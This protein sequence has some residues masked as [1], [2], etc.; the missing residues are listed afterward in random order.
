MGAA[1]RSA[2]G[3]PSSFLRI[4]TG[5]G[6]LVTRALPGEE[7]QGGSPTWR[8]R[9]GE[10]GDRW[11]AGPHWESGGSALPWV[12]A[13]GKLGEPHPQPQGPQ[14]MNMEGP[15]PLCPEQGATSPNPLCVWPQT[16]STGARGSRAGARR[17]RREEHSAG[18]AAVGATDTSS[19]RE[20]R[21]G[22]TRCGRRWE[23][24][25]SAE[26]KRKEPQLETG[27]QGPEEG[28]S[29]AAG[30]RAGHIPP[31][32]GGCGGPSPEMP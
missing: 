16:G 21:R 20:K 26:G 9:A 2:H 22:P 18:S 3:M 32:T 28:F 23:L 24:P 1:V 12:V 5:H 6:E 4:Y 8:T 25:L 27:C 31:D 17:L 29:A 14:S 7:T 19:R 13:T 11:P 10:G 30:G 15:C